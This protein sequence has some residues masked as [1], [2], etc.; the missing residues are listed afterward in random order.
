MI[1]MYGVVGLS[2]IMNNVRGYPSNVSTLDRSGNV[3]LMIG[4]GL[5]IVI[6][7][8]GLVKELADRREDGVG[9]PDTE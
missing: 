1:V 8:I 9:Q 4:G 7:I 3:V 5:W 2:L 6:A